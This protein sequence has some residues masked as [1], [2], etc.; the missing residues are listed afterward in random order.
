VRKYRAVML[1]RQGGLDALEQVEL[2]V[3]EPGPGQVRVRV[4]ATGVG[5]TDLLMWTGYYVYAPPLPFVPGYEVVGRVE[6]IGAGVQSL[7]HGDRVAALIVHGGYAEVLVREASEF[8][9]VPEDL[10]DAEVVATVLNYGTAYQAAHRTARVQKGQTALVVGASGG[11]GTA[12]LEIL[13]C[14]QVKVHGAASLAKHDVVRSLGAIPLDG[15]ADF[16]RELRGHVPSGVDVA[17]DGLGGPFTGRCR[18]ALRW[19]GKLVAYGFT[20]TIHPQ[21]GTYYGALLQG[22]TSLLLASPL[23]LR[24]PAFYGITRLYREDPRPLQEDLGVLFEML[25]H[26]RI[27]PLISARLPLSR[28]REAQAMLERGE[29]AGKIVLMPQM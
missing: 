27:Q 22:L 21:G 1:Q 26:K 16:V 14:A 18:R 19:G 9:K 11:V 8:V 13:R 17:F 5:G 20:S 4:D 23:T 12:L 2:E 24:R 7:A 15:R 6:A 10:D 28:A 29:V 3:P 25:R